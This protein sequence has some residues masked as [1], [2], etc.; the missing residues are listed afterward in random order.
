MSVLPSGSCSVLQRTARWWNTRSAVRSR[1]PSSLNTRPCSPIKNYC[2]LSST[3][4]I[5]WRKVRLFRPVRPGLRS[6]ARVPSESKENLGDVAFIALILWVV[7]ALRQP[8]LTINRKAVYIR[9]VTS[10]KAGS[11][12]P[13]NGLDPGRSFGAW[14][15]RPVANACHWQARPTRHFYYRDQLLPG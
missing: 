15:I 12:P 6:L 3:R 1:R 11:N 5:N 10:A 7:V 14:P 2:K 13:F 4:S 9:A 8:R